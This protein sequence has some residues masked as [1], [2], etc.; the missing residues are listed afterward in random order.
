[1]PNATPGSVVAFAD[2]VQEPVVSSPGL[3]ARLASRLRRDPFLVAAIVFLAALALV[4]LLAPIIAPYDP[5]AQF[6]LTRLRTQPPSRDHWFGT[7][8]FSRDVLSR[9]IDGARVSLTVAFLAVLLA[10]VL[11]TAYGAIAG[12]QGGAVD[13]VMMR[14]LDAC[15]AIPRIL[16]LLTV[17]AL[18]GA[19]SAGPLVIVL[20]LTGWFGV[21]RL[22]RAEVLA[23]KERDFVAAARVAG[24]TAPRMLVRHVIPHV[25]APVLVAATLG[26][27]NIV[28]VEAG[29]SFLGYGIPQPRASWGSIIRDGKDVI[30]TAWWLSLF[31]G[32]ALAATVLAVNVVGDRLREALNPRQLH[33]E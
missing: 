30:A 23:V 10:S 7:D 26:V 17:V 14:A 18:W 22:V 16:L 8:P 31:P 12:F 6:D 25:L 9:V 27:A 5:T 2:A 3:A 33:A 20:G 32:L 1:V 13:T 29:L 15:I 19:L 11:G 28:V 24:A 21:G 4:A